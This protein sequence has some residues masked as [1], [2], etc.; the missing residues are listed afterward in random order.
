MRT[1]V[2]SPGEGTSKTKRQKRSGRP[3]VAAVPVSKS[4]ESH[5]QRSELLQ[6]QN[7][8]AAAKAEKITNPMLDGM[9]P[10]GAEARVHSS[11][12]PINAEMQKALRAVGVDESNQAEALKKLR[13]SKS[14]RIRLDTIKEINRLLDAYPA[15]KTDVEPMTFQLVIDMKV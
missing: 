13:L 6:T 3:K 1:I 7:A 9:K 11:L 14:E 4:G 2:D 10:K 15:P 8:I 5:T 12:R